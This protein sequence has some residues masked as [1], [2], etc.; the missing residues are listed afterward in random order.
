MPINY[1]SRNVKT[2]VGRLTLVASDVAIVAVLWEKEA[3]GRVKLPVRPKKVSKHPILD[4]AVLQLREYFAGSRQTFD[5]PLSP[6]GSAFQSKA[7]RALH[8]IPYGKTSSYQAQA[9]RLGNPKASRAVGAAN[10]RNPISIFIPCHRV[11]GKN[12]KLTGFAGGI[13]V[14]RRLLALERSSCS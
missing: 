14:K 4:R 7:W 12:G 5:L 8:A 3:A 1:Y 11:I 10:G 13:D 2:P 9:S 6:E